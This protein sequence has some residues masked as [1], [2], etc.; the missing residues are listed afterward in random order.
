MGTLSGHLAQGWHGPSPS[1]E[2]KVPGKQSANFI[3]GFEEQPHRSDTI[4]VN[5]PASWRV[6]RDDEKASKT[7]AVFTQ[8]PEIRSFLPCGHGA[9]LVSAFPHCAT[10]PN[11]AGHRLQHCPDSL[12]C[13]LGHASPTATWRGTQTLLTLILTRGVSAFHHRRGRH[14]T[15]C[16]V[17]K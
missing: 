5:L 13:P 15:L 17:I 9:H 3:S 12:N 16:C 10:T 14:H 7:N 1:D 8:K 11:P 6:D 4:P 2:E